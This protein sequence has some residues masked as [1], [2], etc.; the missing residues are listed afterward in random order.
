LTKRDERNTCFD[1]EVLEEQRM[2]F[3]GIENLRGIL[4]ILGM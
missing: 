3:R 1:V 4:I 2:S